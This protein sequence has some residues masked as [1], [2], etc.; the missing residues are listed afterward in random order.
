[1][2]FSD[3][4]I[5]KEVMNQVMNPLY[6]E[7]ILSISPFP[8]SIFNRN[9][10]WLHPKNHF[11]IHMNENQL[12]PKDLKTHSIFYFPMISPL[13]SILILHPKINRLVYGIFDRK[14]PDFMGKQC[15]QPWFPIDFPLNHGKQNTRNKAHAFHHRRSWAEARPPTPASAKG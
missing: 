4:R 12:V 2:P 11:H 13:Y 1:M 14:T 15:K 10:I 6:M 7:H 3:F 9:Q 5:D 8:Y